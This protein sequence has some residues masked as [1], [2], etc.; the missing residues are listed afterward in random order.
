[1]RIDRPSSAAYTP[2]QSPASPPAQKTWQGYTCDIAEMLGH[3]HAPDLRRGAMQGEALIASY[4]SGRSENSLYS[5]NAQTCIIATL[6]DPTCRRGA[7]MHVDHNIRRHIDR[8]VSEVLEKIE[9]GGQGDRRQVQ[10]HMAGGVWWLGGESVG[11]T[12][13]A[14]MRAQ[15]IS[16]Q[17]DHWSFSVCNVH[18]YGMT[19]N[20][21][22]GAVGVF[23]H[24]DFAARDFYH[25]LLLETVGLRN[26]HAQM[27]PLNARADT[28]MRR[29]EAP[30][31]AERSNGEL[32]YVDAELART[33]VPRSAVE[34]QRIRVLR[35]RVLHES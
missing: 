31:I 14:T 22:D 24:P 33:P 19:L 21:K 29:F 28:F 18:T 20:L 10:C 1:M 2:V 8:A 7:I 23:E 32:A 35:E 6:Y 13:A 5:L 4:N 9:A 3:D 11:D 12:V 15:G 25:P 27:P 34:H 30:A 16:P 17:W 26:G